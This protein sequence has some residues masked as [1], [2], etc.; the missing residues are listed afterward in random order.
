MKLKAKKN[1]REKSMK[2]NVGPLKRSIKLA[3]FSWKR[4]NSKLLKSKVKV[5]ALLLTLAKI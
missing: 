1:K 5:G 4:E 2:P 3:T